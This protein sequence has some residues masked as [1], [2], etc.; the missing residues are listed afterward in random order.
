MPYRHGEAMSAVGRVCEGGVVN[1]LPRR[2]EALHTDGDG[3]QTAGMLACGCGNPI[4]IMVTWSGYG[5]LAV[6]GLVVGLLCLVGL[7]LAGFVLAGRLV[8]W[9][10]GD[11]DAD[12][13]RGYEDAPAGLAAFTWEE[14]PDVRRPHHS[15]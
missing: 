8:R 13:E 12:D 9:R 10:W 11:G 6:A 14:S 3:G 1:P 2:W 4:D 5:L 15:P 7:L